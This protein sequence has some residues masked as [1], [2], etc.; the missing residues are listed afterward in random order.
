MALAHLKH[1]L[2][3]PLVTNPLQLS[4]KE[5][6]PNR[7]SPLH[8]YRLAIDTIDNRFHANC[9]RGYSVHRFVVV[10]VLNYGVAG[11]AYGFKPMVSLIES[12]MK[13]IGLEGVRISSLIFSAGLHRV[14]NGLQQAHQDPRHHG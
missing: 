13:R 10:F 5:K 6:M 1:R 11:F 8:L 2:L 7:L 14:P 3:T 4:L 12:G 9:V